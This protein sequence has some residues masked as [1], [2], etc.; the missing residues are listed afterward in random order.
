MT[1]ML[2]LLCFLLLNISCTVGHTDHLGLNQYNID[3]SKSRALA[4]QDYIVEYTGLNK[5]QFVTRFK[6]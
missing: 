3:L 4:V 6:G 1:N 5:N 2:R